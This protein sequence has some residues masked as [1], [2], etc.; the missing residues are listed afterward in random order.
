MALQQ[1]ITYNEHA[2][3]PSLYSAV[4][5]LWREMTAK[6]ELAV[7]SAHTLLLSKRSWFRRG[8][9]RID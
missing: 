1:F 4:E 8:G 2:K 7:R 9:M 5:K 3:E 6:E